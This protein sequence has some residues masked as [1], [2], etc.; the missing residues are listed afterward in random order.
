MVVS[1]LLKVRYLNHLQVENPQT[2]VFYLFLKYIYKMCF[3]KI[4][5]SAVRFIRETMLNSQTYVSA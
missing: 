4:L 5:L 3:F 1:V 2:S